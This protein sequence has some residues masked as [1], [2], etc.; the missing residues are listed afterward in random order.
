MME[1][2]T[3]L[4][5]GTDFP[6]RAFF[7]PRATIIQ[8]D[9]RGEQLGRR[10]KV[11]LGLIGDVKTTLTELLPRLDEKTDSRHLTTS[12]NHYIAARKGLDD[13]ATGEP[14]GAC[15]RL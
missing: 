15:Q 6:Y 9:I 3:L 10:T 7:P 12:V 5:L 13:L 14:G 8:I 11:D 1:A 2:D 4:M